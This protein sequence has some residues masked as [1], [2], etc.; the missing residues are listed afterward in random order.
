M[1]LPV[2]PAVMVRPEE[3]ARPEALAAMALLEAL[4]ATELVAMV[5]PEELE[6]WAEPAAK[7][8]PADSAASVDWAELVDFRP[9]TSRIRAAADA[10]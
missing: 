7:W 10:A 2:E 3:P 9:S 4:V 5:R 6:A 1:A 8:K